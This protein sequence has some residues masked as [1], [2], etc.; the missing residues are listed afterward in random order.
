MAESYVLGRGKI[1]CRGCNSTNLFSAID[2]GDLPIAN[3]LTRT[4]D[5]STE[6]F[7]LHLKIC[8]QCGLGQVEDVVKP[9]RIFSDYRYLSSISTSYVEHARVYVKSVFDDLEFRPTDWVL[10]IASN[11]GY[12]L[13]HFIELGVKVLGLEPAAN[14]MKLALEAGI[15]TEC[16]F[17]GLETA[18]NIL[19]NHGH[20]RLIIANNVLAHVPDIQDFIAGLSVLSGPETLISVENPSVM[21][22]I[23]ADQ[24]DTVYH[25]HFSYL[26]AFS[27]QYLTN[28][29][30]LKLYNVEDISTHGGSNRYWIKK[31]DTKEA[32]SPSVAIKITQ[33]LEG[34]L[35]EQSEWS[36][37]NSRVKGILNDF[38]EWLEE[39]YATGKKVFGYGAAA[40][41]STL[42]NSAR[43]KKEWLEAIADGSNEKQ[44][45]YMPSLGIPILP[46][47]SI[48][49]LNPTDIVIFPWNIRLELVK[50]IRKEF[51][52]KVRI[53]QAVP[54]LRELSNS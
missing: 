41:A 24:F 5:E 1:F 43:I 50:Q 26:S 20:P 34:G 42:L 31:L 3:E 38:S 25:E 36:A 10:E 7:P 16:E 30:G 4:K 18:K 2:L 45:R 6:K 37:L 35:L 39:S 13:R 11:D 14:V 15:P 47:Q 52:P 46:A 53:W 19:K 17:F 40:K 8:P 21:N 32:E 12:L 22:L 48:A 44:G 23:L 28:M 54:A 51:G 27:V 9:E 49:H 29:F 33:E